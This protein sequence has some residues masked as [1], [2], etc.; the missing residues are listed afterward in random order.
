MKTFKSL[1]ALAVVASFTCNAL[2]AHANSTPEL[3]TGAAVNASGTL[4]VQ[5]T[6]LANMQSEPILV[7]LSSPLIDAQGKIDQNWLTAHAASAQRIDLPASPALTRSVVATSIAAP[8]NQWVFVVTDVDH[9]N[10]IRLF[11]VR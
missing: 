8:H 6:M 5:V 1:I 9:S 2:I 10:Q 7:S 11:F 3:A 4:S